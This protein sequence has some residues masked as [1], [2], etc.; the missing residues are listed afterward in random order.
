MFLDTVW[1]L[2]TLTVVPED[3][4]STSSFPWYQASTWYTYI[5]S[6]KSLI[7][8]VKSFKNAFLILIFI[9]KK[10]LLKDSSFLT[11]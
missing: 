10:V 3:P 5:Y 1:W 4:T 8:K 6:D 9:L 7:H 2:T 11:L